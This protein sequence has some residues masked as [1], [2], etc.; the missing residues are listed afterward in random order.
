[1]SPTRATADRKA[2][3]WQRIAAVAA[4]VALAVVAGLLLLGGDDGVI[5]GFGGDG[6]D[7]YRF[8]LRRVS[9]S[10]FGDSR[11]EKVQAVAEDA[12]GNVKETLDQLYLVAFVDPDSWGDYDEAFALFDAPAA[13]SA[14]QDVDV[15]TLGSDASE[16]YD[17]L[18][19]ATG[20]V[21]IVVLTDAR[22][23]PVSA[24][25]TVDF[26]ADAEL[27][28]GTST[29]VRSEGSYF[30]HP[31]GDGWRIYAYRITRDEAAPAGT[32]P[33]GSPS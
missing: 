31:G 24:I 19:P 9:A 20:T 16:E 6:P 10:T 22:D 33:T 3:R 23:R 32:S 13:A 7:G 21:A 26:R 25:A 8:E 27:K 29:S 30:L 15:L 4:V 5:P 12:A 11:R 1:M 2:A 17:R 18:R 28:D 14:E